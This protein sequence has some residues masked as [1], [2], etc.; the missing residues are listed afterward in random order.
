MSIETIQRQRYSFYQLV[1]PR[2]DLPFYVGQTLSFER[3]KQDYLAGKAHSIP[4]ARKLKELEQLRLRPIMEELESRECTQEEA[5]QREAYWIRRRLD[6]G[7]PLINVLS[8]RTGDELKG[9]YYITPEHDMKLERI[10]LARRVK[11]Q[12]IDKSALIREAIDLLSKYEG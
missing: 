9:T 8:V 12:R 11:G 7:M 3:R 6:E 4:L 10:R 1:D 2:A 5:L